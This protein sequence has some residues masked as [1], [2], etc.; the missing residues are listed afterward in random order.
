MPHGTHS[1]ALRH[2]IARPHGTVKECAMK[3]SKVARP[4]AP[5]HAPFWGGVLAAFCAMLSGIGLARFAYT[6][7][8]PALIAAHWFQP[9]A[10]S[11][12]GAANLAGYLLGVTASGALAKQVAPAAILRDA[13][14]LTTAAMAASAWPLDFAWFFAWRLVSG[15]TGGAVMVLAAPSVLAQVPPSRRGIAAGLI[16]LGVGFGI[17]ASGT[18]IP[19][20]LQWGVTVTWLGLA[21]LCLLATIAAW[22]GWPTAPATAPDHTH[23]VRR[24]HPQAGLRAIYIQYGLVAASLVPH[25]I[26]LVDFVARGLHQGITTGAQYWVVFGLGAAAGPLLAGH[27]A[28]R[29]GFESA[30]RLSYLLQALAVSLAIAGQAYGALL[31]SSAIVGALTPGIVPL[32][33][34]R[35]H[36][37]LVHHPGENT[38]A[39][40]R[41]TASFALMQAVSAYGM[42]FLL[43]RTGSYTA[44][45]MLGAAAATL[46]LGFDLVGAAVARPK[47]RPAV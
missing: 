40:P 15:I 19:L 26:F 10:A 11:Y 27:L 30:L 23:H 36:E 29:A 1:T 43:A 44:L 6:P 37:L 20:L 16:F 7:M 4:R 33:L 21:L 2:A 14:V 24:A 12:L 38:R 17:A 18:I 22:H 8:L 34:G 31:V 25:M 41:A 39:W 13:M 28:D 47:E 45:F 42:S 5:Q 3:S 32:V 35:I 9:A 46:A